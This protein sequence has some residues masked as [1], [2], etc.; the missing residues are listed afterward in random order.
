MINFT[1]AD[2]TGGVFCTIYSYEILTYT[3]REMYMAPPDDLLAFY[4]RAKLPLLT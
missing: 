4:A 3:S 1:T 2:T